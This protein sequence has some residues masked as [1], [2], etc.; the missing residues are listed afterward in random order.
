[1]KLTIDTRS[2]GFRA[3]WQ[4]GRGN[5]GR[6]L[7]SSE[8]ELKDWLVRFDFASGRPVSSEEAAARSFG[9]D[10]ARVGSDETAFTGSN[11]SYSAFID[12][13]GNLIESNIEHDEESRG[14]DGE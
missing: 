11:R 8:T 13:A 14:S 3:I 1:M 10:P 12:D 7:L 5:Q 6:A 9:F 2:K 4:D